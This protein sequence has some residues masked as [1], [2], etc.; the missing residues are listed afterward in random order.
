MMTFPRRQNIAKMTDAEFQI[1]KSV[2]R[3]EMMGCNPLLT[4]AITLLQQARDKVS[5][6]VDR[7]MNVTKEG[8]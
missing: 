4:E 5:D 7:D 2:Q 1:Y 6:Y 8:E 3:V